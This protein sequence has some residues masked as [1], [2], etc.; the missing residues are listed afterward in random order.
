MVFNFC[1]P[2]FQVY[3]G[4]YFLRNNPLNMEI[5][6]RSVNY[7][8]GNKIK[9]LFLRHEGYLGTVGAFL[10]GTEQWETESSS[11]GSLM[12]WRWA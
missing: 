2:G 10:K 12:V 8:S 6:S 7:W 3:F 4:G 1:F 11:S 5:L 9:A